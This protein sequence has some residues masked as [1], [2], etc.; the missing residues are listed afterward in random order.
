METVYKEGKI[1]KQKTKPT[2]INNY[3]DS[4]SGMSTKLC[5]PTNANDASAQVIMLCH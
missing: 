2:F 5:N 4:F 3:N 1:S